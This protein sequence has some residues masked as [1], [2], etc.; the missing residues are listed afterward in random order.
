M[1]TLK[2]FEPMV[3]HLAKVQKLEISEQLEKPSQSAAAVIGQADAI[4]AEFDF[5][6]G[7]LRPYGLGN[8]LAQ[9]SCLLQRTNKLRDNLPT[10]FGLE[11]LS[12]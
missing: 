11:A 7:Q 1:E 8:G 2:R 10:L 4:P 5:F 9:Q 3:T 12:R 6:G